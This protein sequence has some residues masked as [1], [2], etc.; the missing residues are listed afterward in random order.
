MILQ[1]NVAQPGILGRSACVCVQAFVVFVWCAHV[2]V[3]PHLCGCG[4]VGAY[5]CGVCGVCACMRTHLCVHVDAY[6]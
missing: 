2:C 3:Q 1:Q 6:M 5:V 4:C